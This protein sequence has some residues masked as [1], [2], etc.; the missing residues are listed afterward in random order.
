[1]AT[2]R[3][4][5]GSDA[6]PAGA[7]PAADPAEPEAPTLPAEELGIDRT[8]EREL[9]A[10]FRGDVYIWDVAGRQRPQVLQSHLSSV[11]GVAISP[12]GRTL[13]SG[14]DNGLIKLWA[15][16]QH[17]GPFGSR[18]HVRELLMLKAHDGG[19]GNLDF[20]PDGRTLAS[21]G[22]E[23]SVRLWRAR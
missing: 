15:L 18:L 13:A 4:D 21:C 1:M 23:G 3:S 9:E 7:E 5:R 11:R 20:S 10:S 17:R 2:R 14:D 12:D 19:V 6:S 8:N 16:E 22:R